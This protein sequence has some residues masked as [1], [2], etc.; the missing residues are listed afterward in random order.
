MMSSMAKQDRRKRDRVQ[1]H[2]LRQALE[3][4]PDTRSE[5]SAQ[6]LKKVISDS[7]CLLMVRSPSQTILNSNNMHLE[8]SPLSH[9]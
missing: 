8:R 7:R 2:D 9:E 6:E 3:A 1:V 5:R 4:L